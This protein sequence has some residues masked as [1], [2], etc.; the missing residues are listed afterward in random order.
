MVHIKDNPID[1]ACSKYLSGDG[2]AL[3]NIDFKSA[4]LPEEEREEVSFIKRA[5]ALSEIMRRE[6]PL[7]LEDRLDHNDIAARD[8]FEYGIPM[9]IDG[10]DNDF[11]DTVLTRLTE[12]EINPVR[13]NLAL[14]KKEAVLLINAGENTRIVAMTL[15]AY[16]DRDV[17]GAAEKE[18]FND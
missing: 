15:F 4:I 8:V 16:F 11:I 6:G 3:C 18:L 17:A 12:H 1:T 9:I 7:A 14:A 2:D 10:Y 13:K 5:V